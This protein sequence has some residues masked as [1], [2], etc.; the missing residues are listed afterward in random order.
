MVSRECSRPS[1]LIGFARLF[2]VG[3]KMKPA[4]S[5]KDFEFQA[6]PH[7]TRAQNALKASNGSDR[8]TVDGENPVAAHEIRD[9]RPGLRARHSMRPS[10]RKV[11]PRCMGLHAGYR[12]GYP[13][14]VTSVRSSQRAKGGNES[15]EGISGRCGW[16]SRKR[17][18]PGYSRVLSCHCC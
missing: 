16:R 12:R 8:I 2:Y 7:R 14:R 3:E 1:I 9:P 5:P 18:L 4:P 10:L 17:F 6:C 13:K 15:P 11:A